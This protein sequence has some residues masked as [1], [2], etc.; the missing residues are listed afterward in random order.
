MPGGPTAAARLRT[1]TATWSLD[2]LS[3]TGDTRADIT[4]QYFRPTAMRQCLQPARAS[5]ISTDF[6]SSVSQAL[7]SA[8]A[9]GNV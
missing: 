4:D 3:M 1:E 7:M 5:R 8:G 6:S 9:P 2:Q